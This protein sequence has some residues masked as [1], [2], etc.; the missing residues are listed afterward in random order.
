MVALKTSGV[1]SSCPHSSRRL[2]LRRRDG[3]V[4]D[5]RCCI[6]LSTFHKEIESV[7]VSG[8]EMSKFKTSGVASSCP[9]S[10]HQ[11]LRRRE[12]GIKTSTV[13]SSCP[14][15]SHPQSLRRGDGGIKTISVTS[16]CPHSSCRLSLRRRDGGVE[17]IRCCIVLSTLH[18]EIASIVVSGEDMSALKTSSVASSCPHS[19]RRSSQSSQAKRWRH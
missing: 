2:F 3:G 9:H 17:D 5:I 1:A 12:G 6:V 16:P 4:E 10:S 7:V 18:S 14:H 19:S 8:E 11:S 13:A 15:S